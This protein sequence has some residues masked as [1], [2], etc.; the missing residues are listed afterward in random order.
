[1][2]AEFRERLFERRGGAAAAIEL[3][4]DPAEETMLRAIPKEQLEQIIAQT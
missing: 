4:L 2:D 1:V 3:H